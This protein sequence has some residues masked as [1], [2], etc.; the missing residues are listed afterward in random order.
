MLD[1]FENRDR[2]EDKL[3]KAK[4]ELHISSNDKKIISAFQI[5]T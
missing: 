3:A 1:E 2:L 4:A 5:S